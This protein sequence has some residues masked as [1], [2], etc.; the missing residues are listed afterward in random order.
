MELTHPLSKIVYARDDSAARA[1]ILR[2]ALSNRPY[3]GWSLA[4][5]MINLLARCTTR[6]G[7][8]IRAK[9]TALRRLL[10]HS[11]P[12]TRRF[13]AELRLKASTTMAHHAA[14]TPNSL[15][16]SLPPAKSLLR[17]PW[18]SSP[19]PHLCLD[20]QINS[21]PARVRLV[22]TPKTLCQPL[23]RFIAGNG[24]SSCSSIPGSGGLLSGSLLAMNRYLLWPIQLGTKFTSATSDLYP[25][26]IRPHSDTGRA[27]LLSNL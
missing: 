18:T 17:T 26:D 1:A 25:P 12:N 6:P 19:L 7:R 14:L 5:R 10:A 3:E 15:E 20:H 24:S 27:T 23:D 11:P 4:K 13:I 22:T 2:R 9:R 8:A 21:S 16:G